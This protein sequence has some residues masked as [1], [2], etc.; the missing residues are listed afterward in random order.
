LGKLQGMFG[1]QFYIVDN[2]RG[3]PDLTYVTKSID[4]WL[5]KTPSRPAAKEWIKQQQQA[6]AGAANNSTPGIAP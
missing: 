1:Q 4:G 3:V 6:K 2:N 5:A